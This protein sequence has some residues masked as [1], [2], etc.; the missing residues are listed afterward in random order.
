[1]KCSAGASS[2]QAHQLSARAHVAIA[3]Q[4]VHQ[5]WLESV[6]CSDENKDFE[7]DIYKEEKLI[8]E[9]KP[10]RENRS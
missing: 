2:W 8:P 1:M 5:L 9:S 3:L 4:N 6:I 7:S 10:V